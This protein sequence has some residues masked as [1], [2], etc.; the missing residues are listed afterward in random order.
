LAKPFFKTHADF[1]SGID[2]E[3]RTVLQTHDPRSLAEST[4]HHID[5]MGL[6]ALGQQYSRDGGDRPS[7][8]E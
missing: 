6:V 3:R 1:A 4:Q 2:V 8:W 7:G 5:E